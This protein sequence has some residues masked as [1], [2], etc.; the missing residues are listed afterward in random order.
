MILVQLLAFIHTE[1]ETTVCT[2]CAYCALAVCT[3][4][5]LNCPFVGNKCKLVSMSEHPFAPLLFPVQTFTLSV[6]TLILISLWFV[7][8][9]EER[10]IL[11]TNLQR[12]LLHQYKLFQAYSLNPDSLRQ[13]KVDKTLIMSHSTTDRDVNSSVLC[14]LSN[15]P[16]AVS[17]Q[18][19]KNSWFPAAVSDLLLTSCN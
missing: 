6:L 8:C 17:R 16:W 19:V 13:P 14:C 7:C 11:Q 1:F 10:V 12:K 5:V 3:L 15:Y 18:R 9:R 2:Y 4:T